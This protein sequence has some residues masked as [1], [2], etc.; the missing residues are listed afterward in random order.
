MLTRIVIIGSRITALPVIAMTPSVTI[1]EP[2]STDGSPAPGADG[3]NVTHESE[4]ASF[5][6]SA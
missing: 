4:I 3:V 5:A 1:I 6:P 2:L